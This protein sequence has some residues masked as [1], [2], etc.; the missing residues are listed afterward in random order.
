MMIQH[1]C[2]IMGLRVRTL[3]GCRG[4]VRPKPGLEQV[5]RARGQNAKLRCGIGA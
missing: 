2:W 4:L 1:S 3:C 5:M